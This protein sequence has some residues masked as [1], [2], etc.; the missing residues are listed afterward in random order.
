MDEKKIKITFPNG[1]VME[2]AYRT[3]IS[4]ILDSR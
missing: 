4:D 3:R 2:T 1:K